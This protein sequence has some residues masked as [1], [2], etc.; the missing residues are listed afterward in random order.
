MASLFL[1]EKYYVPTRVEELSRSGGV[2]IYV[3]ID[4][5]FQLVAFDIDMNCLVIEILA[6]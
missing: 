4:L 1:L 2:P 6:D 3:T 5:I